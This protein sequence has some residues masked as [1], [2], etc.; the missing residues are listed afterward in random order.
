MSLPEP[1]AAE[2]LSVCRKVVLVCERV[3]EVLDRVRTA[4]RAERALLK[5]NEDTTLP[6]RVR[7]E[8]G[9]ALWG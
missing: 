7:A 9:V 3:E 1:L 4:E 8:A 2:I 6:M 5:I